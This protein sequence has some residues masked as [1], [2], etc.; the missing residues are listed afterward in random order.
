MGRLSGGCWKVIRNVWEVVWRVL[1]D[2]LV[3]VMRL[4][5]GCGEGPRE[6]A[7]AVCG[8]WRL[9]GGCGEDVWIVKQG[10]LE[11]KTRLS[12]GCG[13]AVSKVCGAFLEVARR[14]S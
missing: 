8:V 1:G 2:C 6:C 7:E 14:L 12:A 11:G 3:G 13:V 10:C 9:S 5:G 4:P